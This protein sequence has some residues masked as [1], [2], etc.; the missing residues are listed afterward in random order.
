MERYDI[1]DQVLNQLEYYAHR[2]AFL[3]WLGEHE[4]AEV[5]MSSAHAMA[6]YADSQEEWLVVTEADNC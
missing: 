2:I 6:E 3:Q 5:L 4:E 1:T